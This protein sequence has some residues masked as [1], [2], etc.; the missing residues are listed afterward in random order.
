MEERHWWFLARRRIL[1][2]LLHALLPPSRDTLLIDV[3]CGTGGLTNFFSKQYTIIGV[4]PSADAITFARERFPSSTFIHGKAPDDV[5]DFSRA[6]AILLIEVLEHI[7]HDRDFVHQ[8]I[9]A[10]KSGAY[11][12]IMAPADMSLWS[13]HDDAFEH[14]RRYESLEDFRNIWKGTPISER[15][16]SYCN[17]RL[18]PVVKFMRAMSKRRGKSWGKGG[19]DIAVPMAPLNALLKKTFA[20]EERILLNALKG[21][22]CG[23]KKGV[24]VMAVLQKK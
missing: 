22:G 8:L 17:R 24:S 11:L 1:A 5:P 2:T 15:L 16:V 10:M 12:F 6:D 3:G 18:Y 23:Y 13:P 4:D 14:F 7:E 21:K 19:T 9:T 20:G